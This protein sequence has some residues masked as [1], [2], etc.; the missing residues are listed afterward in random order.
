[1]N[2]S[3]GLGQ[4][5]PGQPDFDGPQG[6]AR[7]PGSGTS[8]GWDQT[9][10]QYGA[11]QHAQPDPTGPAPSFGSAPTPPAG[12]QGWSSPTQA[13]PQGE[14]YRPGEPYPPTQAYPQGQPYPQGQQYPQG[15]AYS[16]GQPYLQGQ[17]PY[18]NPGHQPP[19]N[20]QPTQQ[21]FGNQAF[22][23]PGTQPF[24]QGGYQPPVQT[25]P[26][27]PSG[28]GGRGLILAGVVIGLLIVGLLGWQFLGPSA[29]QQPSASASPATS[30]PASARATAPGTPQPRVTRASQSP[31]PTTS[32]QASGGGIGTSVSFRTRNGSG[33]VT[34]TKATWVDNGLLEPTEGQQYLIV[35]LTLT[36]VSGAVTTGPFFASVVD[37]DSENHMLSIG[38]A[39]DNQLSMRTLKPG[40]VNT[41]QIAFELEPGPVTFQVL[42]E[43]LEPVARVEIPG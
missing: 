19:G 38:A 35:D 3:D 23:Q 33:T 36:G 5:S 11:P 31:E 29:S 27:R 22:G 41:G 43:L 7:P 1:V 17:S 18:A 14:Q 26:P 24:G 15:P 16:P 4:P 30:V 25:A 13:Y 28:S 40:E 20:G 39:L 34:V 10:P 6:D 37:A 12:G 9:Q 21:G 2:S 8:A 32:A 42:D